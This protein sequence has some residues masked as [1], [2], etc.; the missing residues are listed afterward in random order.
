MHT[1]DPRRG[2]ILSG[3]LL[4]ALGIVVLM[5]VAGVFVTRNIRIITSHRRGGDDVSIDIPGG[6]LNVRAHGSLNPTSLGIPIYPGA[7]QN[8]DGG[9][10]AVE[11]SSSDGK[12]D[13]AIAV[14]GAELITQ[15]SSDQVLAYYRNQLPNWVIATNRDGSTRL[16]LNK[17]GYK[18]IV[19]IKETRDGTHIG[20]ATIGEPASN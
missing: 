15:D 11:W 9:G 16:E 10:A 20:V 2:G 4:T 3:L 8:H 5:V 6:H 1:E 12:E 13:K 7:V 18:R 17:D 19:A 14:A